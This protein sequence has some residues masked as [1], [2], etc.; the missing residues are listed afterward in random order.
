[1]AP[2]LFQDNG[3]YSYYSDFWS[4]GCMMLEMATGK[5][6][7]YTSSLKELIQ[8]I[9][10]DEVKPVDGYSV[11]FNDLIKKMLQK[12]PIYRVNWD[13]IKTH[14]WWDATP[15]SSGTDKKA[16]NIKYKFKFT[17]RIYQPQL[18]FDKYL[19]TVRNIDPQVFHQMRNK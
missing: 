2:E 10:V 12:D 19:Q 8:K 3:V 17:K 4:L 7:F 9:I 1:M 11:E 6:P 16:K 5:P 15:P 18:H 13:E 14:P